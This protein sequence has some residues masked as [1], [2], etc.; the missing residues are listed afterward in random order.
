MNFEENES[1][2]QGIQDFLSIIALIR[3][4]VKTM[5]RNL[6]SVKSMVNI[7]LVSCTEISTEICLIRFF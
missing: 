1:K 2:E 3:T 5:D 6:R 7:Y 4:M